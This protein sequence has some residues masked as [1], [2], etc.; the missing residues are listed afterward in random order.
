MQ[1]I[2]YYIN[3]DDDITTT[4][5][6]LKEKYDIE[7]NDFIDEDDEIIEDVI[8]DEDIEDNY[9][10]IFEKNDE[11]ENI[12]LKDILIEI[13]LLLKDL[14]DEKIYNRLIIDF[15]NEKIDEINDI[16]IV[17]NLLTSNFNYNIN[18][19]IRFLNNDD[20]FNEITLKNCLKY[21]IRNLI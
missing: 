6:D 18:D 12:D 11:D 21:E 2:I 20:D 3:N 14:E 10:N 1:H 4:I 9:I 16:N 19:V 15:L 7:I 13:I 5:E 17:I 8:V